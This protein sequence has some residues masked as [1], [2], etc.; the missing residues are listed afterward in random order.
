MKDSQQPPGTSA[1]L[2]KY[3]KADNERFSTIITAL[4]CHGVSI[5]RLIMK[6]SQPKYCR[7]VSIGKY[8][9]ADNERFST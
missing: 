4:A 5:S 8:I 3:I 2:C 1:Q 9:K 6:D 7:G